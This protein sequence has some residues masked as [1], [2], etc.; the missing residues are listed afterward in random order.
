MQF[1]EMICM[2][3]FI[4]ILID[5]KACKFFQVGAGFLKIAKVFLNY[6]LK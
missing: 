3:F 1:Q 4:E 6:S 5:N 2:V